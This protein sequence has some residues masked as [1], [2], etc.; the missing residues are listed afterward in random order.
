MPEPDKET[1]RSRRSRRQSLAPRDQIL[2]LDHLE[3]RL[4]WT[5]SGLMALLAISTVFLWIRNPYVVSSTSK[6]ASGTCPPGSHLQSNTCEIRSHLSAGGWEFR[7]LFIVVVGIVLTY[8][9][10]RKKR[11]GVATFSIFLGLGSSA[12]VGPLSL[13]GPVFLL[14]GVWLIMRAFRLQKYGESSFRGANKAAREQAAVRKSER[15][16]RNSSR[17]GATTSS[18]PRRSATP[19]PSKRYTPKKTQTR[20]R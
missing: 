19:A 1:Q 2:G 7:L 8:F 12:I 9:A 5:A 18:D 11:A 10:W 3:Q 17:Q 13:I 15:N 14:F 16:G 6:L 20:R 4:S